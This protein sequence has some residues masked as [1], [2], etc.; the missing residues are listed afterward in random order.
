[1][2]GNVLHLSREPT[3]ITAAHWVALQSFG[4]PSIE[5]APFDG[6]A[7]DRDANPPDLVRGG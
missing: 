7:P 2:P 4:S 3:V 5:S 1:M 6:I